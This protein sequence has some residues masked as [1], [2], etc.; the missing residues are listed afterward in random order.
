M[1]KLKIMKKTNFSILGI[2]SLMAMSFTTFN[3]NQIDDN[4]LPIKSTNFINVKVS[5]A[6]TFVQLTTLSTVSNAVL[7]GYAA[8]QGPYGIFGKTEQ[9]SDDK[10][11]EILSKY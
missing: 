6:K 10:I 1:N 11:E 9:K 5:G 3:G 7:D 8:T 4:F 2:V